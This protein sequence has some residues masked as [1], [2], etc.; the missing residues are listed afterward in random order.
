MGIRFICLS[1][2]LKYILLLFLE[3]TY[4]LIFYI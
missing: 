2:D 3:K 4:S 1:L